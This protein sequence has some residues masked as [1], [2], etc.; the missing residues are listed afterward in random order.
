MFEIDL[1]FRKRAEKKVEAGSHLHSYLSDISNSC[2]GRI[3][4]EHMLHDCNDDLQGQEFIIQTLNQQGYSKLVFHT[5]NINLQEC[6][7]QDPTVQDPDMLD[8]TANDDI[9]SRLAKLGASNK[10]KSFFSLADSNQD[11]SDL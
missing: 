3:K 7:V 2:L 11:C 10:E 9:L 8:S 1:L 5:D 4:E 6:G